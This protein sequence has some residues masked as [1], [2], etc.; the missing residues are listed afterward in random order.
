MNMDYWNKRQQIWDRAEKYA[1]GPGYVIARDN[2]LRELVKMNAHSPEYSYNM[3]VL[4]NDMN[5]R[6]TPVGGRIYTSL[7]DNMRYGGN[8]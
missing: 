8:E 2:P 4:E 3:R 6:E 1:E 7:M 5:A